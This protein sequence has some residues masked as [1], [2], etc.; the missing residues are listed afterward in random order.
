MDKRQDLELDLDQ[1]RLMSELLRSSALR[2]CAR[3]GLRYS[4]PEETIQDIEAKMQQY[5]EHTNRE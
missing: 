4:S 5:E 3:H 1:L 2:A